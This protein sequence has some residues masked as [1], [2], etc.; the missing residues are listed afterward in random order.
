MKYSRSE[1]PSWV[2][3]GLPSAIDVFLEEACPQLGGDLTREPVVKKIIELVDEYLPSSERMRQG[4]VLWYAVDEAE[5]SGYGKKIEKCKTK[6]VIVDLLTEGD[7]DDMMKKVPKKDRMQK[8]AVRLFEQSYEQKGI[9]TLS[10]VAA[11][12]KL[13]E[14]TISKYI[15]E[16]EKIK[17]EV[18]PR[19]GTIHDM[20]PTL[21]HKKIICFKY[22]K[23]GKTVEDVCRETR[24]SKEAVARYIDAFARVYECLK[25]NWSIERIS[26]VTALSKGL[27]KQYVDLIQ[28]EEIEFDKSEIP[29]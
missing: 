5:S 14:G 21:T 7:I 19:R 13:S 22:Y 4:Q 20:G 16:Y 11:I 23:E 10:D 25:E 26:Q 15:R 2:R 24:H 1:K 29:R 17:N 6:P 12:L 8:I 9:F 27:T 18:I 28:S 3:K